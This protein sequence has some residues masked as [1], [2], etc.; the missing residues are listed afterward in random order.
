MLVTV[1]A[2][3]SLKIAVIRTF[4]DNNHRLG[5]ALYNGF[6]AQAIQLTERENTMAKE[7]HVAYAAKNHGMKH[8]CDYCN[9]H[10]VIE[11]WHVLCYQRSAPEHKIYAGQVYDSW[12]DIIPCPQCKN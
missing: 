4:A 11:D 2:T 10:G 1:S 5:A 9:G 6:A 7:G 12:K 3:V 8:S